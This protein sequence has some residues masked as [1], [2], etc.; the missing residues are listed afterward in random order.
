MESLLPGDEYTGESW[1]PVGEYTGESIT[2]TY[3]FLKSQQNLKCF[4]GMSNR[5]RRSCLMKKTRVKKPCD[6]V[7]LKGEEPIF[8][9]DLP[10]LSHVKS[11]FKFPCHLLQELES[12]GII[13]MP[14]MSCPLL[15]RM[16]K[17][18]PDIPLMSLMVIGCCYLY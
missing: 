9:A 10:I 5:T 11:P 3:N 16:E 18:V 7:P 14:D 8:S 17:L 12:N 6:T 13:T 2:N 1:L 15:T 4:L